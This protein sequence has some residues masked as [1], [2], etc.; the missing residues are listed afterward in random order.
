MSKLT[1]ISIL[2]IWLFTKDIFVLES[3]INFSNLFSCV[4]SSIFLFCA[5]YEV[6]NFSRVEE[7][8]TMLFDFNIITGFTIFSTQFNNN[9]SNHDKGRV[10]FS[11]SEFLIYFLY[12]LIDPLNL[13]L[14]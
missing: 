14:I 11:M 1:I 13:V 7:V 12:F 4:L 2:A 3:I 5:S 10:S 8:V 9:D 6:I